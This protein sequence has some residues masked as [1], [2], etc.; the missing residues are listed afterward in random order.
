MIWSDLRRR[1]NIERAVSIIGT[2]SAMIGIRIAMVVVPFKPP[3]RD[4]TARMKPRK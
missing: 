1:R 3:W 2:P 4:R